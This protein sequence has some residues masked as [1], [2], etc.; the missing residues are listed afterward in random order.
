MI[1]CVTMV[2]CRPALM[3]TRQPHSWNGHSHRS[4]KGVWVDLCR[5]SQLHWHSCR[6][7]WRLPLYRVIKCSG[8][9]QHQNILGWEFMS[10]W[11]YHSTSNQKSCLLKSTTAIE[12]RGPGLCD[13][14]TTGKIARTR[15]KCDATMNHLLVLWNHCLNFYSFRIWEKCQHKYAIFIRDQILWKVKSY[16]I[17]PLSLNLCGSRKC[18]LRRS[19][20]LELTQDYVVLCR[21]E[22]TM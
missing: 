13:K 18:V 8:S 7:Y 17:H 22:G 11:I 21:C 1:F 9:R 16:V 5:T 10:C 19:G 4:C 15:R 3:H 14:G 12:Y 2:L 20:D 6:G